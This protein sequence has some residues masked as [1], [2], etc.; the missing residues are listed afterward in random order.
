MI[1]GLIE[2]Q[3]NSKNFFFAKQLTA[4]LHAKGIALS[5][6]VIASEFNRF[7]NMN[8][9]KP[10]TVRKW[11]LGVSMPRS[12]T[13]L[14]LAKWLNVDPNDLFKV[15]QT[16]AEL[17]NKVSVEF[18]FTDQEVISKYLAMTVKEKVTVRLVIDAIAE[19]NK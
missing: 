15:K 11:L 5:P 17:N 6:S 12:D 1:K 2:H 9:T 14:L 7:L 19:K 3:S 4:L 10:H 13:L 8:V 16:R 18:D